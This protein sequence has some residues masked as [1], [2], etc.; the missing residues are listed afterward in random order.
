M[1]K[2]TY[3][4]LKFCS[5]DLTTFTKMQIPESCLN[6]DIYGKLPCLLWLPQMQCTVPAV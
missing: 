1:S 3:V 4:S 6:A 2:K 5:S